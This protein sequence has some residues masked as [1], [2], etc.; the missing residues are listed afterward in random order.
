MTPKT[1]ALVAATIALM[2]TRAAA[3]HD[4]TMARFASWLEGEFNNYAQ[5]WQQKVDEVEA[6]LANVH[7]RFVR[8]PASD[9][10]GAWFVA[11][12]S[13]VADAGRG[14]RY[15]L[16]FEAAADGAIRQSAMPLAYDAA[17]TDSAALADATLAALGGFSPATDCAAQWHWRDEYFMAQATA[18]CAFSRAPPGRRR[19]SRTTP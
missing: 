17:D 18:E 13:D 3:A 16:R 2:L 6:P 11:E 10:T 9:E 4:A 7:Y 19:A 12:R 15:L 14:E 8:V 1:T 5:V